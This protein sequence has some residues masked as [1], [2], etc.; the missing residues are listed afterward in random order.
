MVPESSRPAHG[1]QGPRSD[2]GP[3]SSASGLD[4]DLRR[5]RPLPAEHPRPLADQPQV[6]VGRQA[7]VGLEAGLGGGRVRDLEDR[8]P[9]VDLVEHGDEDGVGAEPGQLVELLPEEPAAV[10]GDRRGRG[11]RPFQVRP[12]EAGVDDRQP[13]DPSPLA[14]PLVLGPVIHGGVAP[15]LGVGRVVGDVPGGVGV[16]PAE[17]GLPGGI[18]VL[19]PVPVAPADE[20]GGVGAGGLEEVGE[21]VGQLG[22]HRDAGHPP[23]VAPDLDDGL[24]AVVEVA[25]VAGD[26]GVDQASP[27]AAQDVEGP[28]GRHP[29]DVE[30]DRPGPARG[31]GGLADVVEH[32]EAR[33]RA[34]GR[35]AAGQVDD[36]VLEPGAVDPVVPHPLEVA[37]D[38]G[39]VVGAE[40][41]GRAAVGRG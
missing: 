38:R 15:A 5:D 23:V 1:P 17:R 10:A 3:F 6:P 13:G 4:R 8:R 14:F 39:R 16:E 40:Q 24:A 19:T 34:I 9:L 28:A 32:P 41:L 22:R 33:G 11:G 27:L 25:I 21:L 29:R 20:V 31:P 12:G 30:G 26:A 18:G 2:L 36:E 37:E 35:G 7:L